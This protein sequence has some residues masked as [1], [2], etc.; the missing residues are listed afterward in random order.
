VSSRLEQDLGN[1]DVATVLDNFLVDDLGDFGSGVLRWAVELESLRSGVVIVQHALQSSSDIN[2]LLNVN[3]RSQY[4]EE[5][6]YVDW[7]VF[8]LHVVG[9]E[10]VG[11]SSKFV[12]QVIFKSEH[13]GRAHN[14]SLGEDFANNT[15]A[16]ALGLEEIRGRILSSV[17]GRN[18]DESVDVVL[19]NRLGN[20]L[21]TVN[22]DVFVGKV[23][24]YVRYDRTHS[25]EES[26]TL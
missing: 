13:W 9:G 2:G 1:V 16:P 20:A 18:V 6:T 5:Y 4:W 15:L 21:R 22:V 8:L 7:P 3:N 11:H 17:V 24:G 26:R 14:G 25:I 19:R 10:E 23:P 12:K